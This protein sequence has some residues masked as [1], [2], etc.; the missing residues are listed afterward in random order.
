AERWTD[1]LNAPLAIIHKR[2]DPNI[3]NEVKV[4]EVVGDVSGRV[5]VLVDDMIDTG[6]TIVK[7]A[8]AL[9]DNG[10]AEVIVA[11]TH[12]IFS[13]PAVDRLKNSRISEVVVTDTLPIGEDRRF[14]KLTVL[15]IAPLLAR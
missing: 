12:G 1:T 6:G 15:P 11:A 3:A 13:G 2:R 9:F 7:A 8:D 14:D 10:A 4:A 5:C